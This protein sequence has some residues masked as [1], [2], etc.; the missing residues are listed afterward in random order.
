MR[1]IGLSQLGLTTTSASDGF[2]VLA[3]ADELNNPFAGALLPEAEPVIE[4]GVT[5]GVHALCQA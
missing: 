3:L 5:A 2:T 1:T 4:E